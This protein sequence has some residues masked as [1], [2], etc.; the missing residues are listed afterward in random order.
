MSGF[1]LIE[2]LVVIAIIA[3]LAG[4]L[5]PALAHVKKTTKI[6]VAKLEM[7]SLITAIKQYE[8]EY[9]RMPAPKKAEL[10]ALNNADCPDFTYGT[11]SSDGKALSPA[12]PS[13]TSYGSPDYQADNSELL[14]ILLGGKS[15]ATPAL[16]EIAQARNPRK[17]SFFQAKASSSAN[18]PGLGQDGV[19]RDPFGNPYIITVDMNDDNKTLDGFYGRLRKVS[20]TTPEVDTPVIVWTFGPDG[21]ANAGDDSEVG[22]KDKENKDNIVSWE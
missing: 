3:I 2:L 4:L 5:L 15:A 14:A 13:I 16:S 7:L 18:G 8:T 17:H 12:N 20:G 9:S 19:L 10:C 11:V 6:K 1:T 22:I 21:R